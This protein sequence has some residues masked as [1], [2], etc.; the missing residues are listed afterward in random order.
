MIF[1]TAGSKLRF[2]ASGSVVADISITNRLEAYKLHRD[3]NS[4]HTLLARSHRS[5][6][7]EQRGHH[8]SWRKNLIVV[9]EVAEARRK[10]D[11]LANVVV[12]L[13]QDHSPGGNTG[14]QGELG[15]FAI[16]IDHVDDGFDHR[17]WFNS[18]DHGAITEPLG[19]TDAMD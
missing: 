3:S 10:V 18:D 4:R 1:E 6:V 17:L 11:R 2:S 12:T 5:C 19:D 8:G 16:R 15:R 14:P 9:R 7:D 13:E